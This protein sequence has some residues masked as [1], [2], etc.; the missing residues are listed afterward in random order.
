VVTLSKV[1]TEEEILSQFSNFPLQTPVQGQ[2]I[3]FNPMSDEQYNELTQKLSAFDPG[4]IPYKVD[5]KFGGTSQ[6]LAIEGLIASFTG[7]TIVVFVSFRTFVP[8]GAVILSAFADIVM[9]AATMN[10]LG[11]TL[12]LGTTAALLM[13]IG[14]SVDSDILLTTRVLKRKGK[15]EEKFSGAFRTGIVMTTTTMAAVGAMWVVSSFGSIQIIAEI[16]SVLFIGLIFDI[17]NTWLTNA[18]L[19]KWYVEKRG[20]K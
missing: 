16:A 19:L 14:Y 20:E 2:V 18:G 6:T 9:T 17:F 4:F 8:S 15:I 7:M 11:I 3:R 5:P 12:S 1:Y 13:L 10:I